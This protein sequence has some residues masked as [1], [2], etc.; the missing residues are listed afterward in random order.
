M[1]PD[2]FKQKIVQDEFVEWEEV[3]PGAYYGT[4]KY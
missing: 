3:Y 4:L 2:E 1:T